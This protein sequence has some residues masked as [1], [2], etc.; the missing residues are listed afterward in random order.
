MSSEENNVVNFRLDRLE[1]AVEKLSALADVVTRWDAKFASQGTF[2]NCT[3][4]QARMES[5]EKKL[6]E[7]YKITLDRT[8]GYLEIEQHEIAIKAAQEEI[9]AMKSFMNRAI[10]AMVIL[11]IIIQLVGPVA[12]DYIKGHTHPV[13]VQDAAAGFNLDLSRMSNTNR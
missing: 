3:V 9:G 10:G 5:Y 13:Q 4:H 7:I 11:S 1:L 6:D 8:K 12:V 2:M